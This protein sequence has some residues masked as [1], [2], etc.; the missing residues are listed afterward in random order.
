[1]ESST[2]GDLHS[3]VQDFE[4]N[5]QHPRLPA[6]EGKE[7]YDPVDLDEKR[8]A[9][10]SSS[11]SRSSH[12]QNLAQLDSKVAKIPNS[13]DADAVFAHLP[14]HEAAILKR[15]LEIPPVNVSYRTLYR[16][17]TKW[18][19]VIMVISAFCACAGGA[20]QPLMTVRNKFNIYFFNLNSAGVSHSVENR[21]L[22]RSV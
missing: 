20:I 12:D 9:D 8:V 22:A 13:Q 11:P 15:Q 10:S 2:G 7:S 18:D 19:I 3:G 17:A 4:E 16:Y 21:G 5:L 14:A 6:A 1:M